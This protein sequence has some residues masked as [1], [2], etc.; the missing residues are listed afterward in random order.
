MGRTDQERVSQQQRYSVSISGTKQKLVIAG[1]GQIRKELEK[2]AKDLKANVTFL[3][4]VS[5]ETH[6]GPR[7]EARAKPGGT[8]SVPLAPLGEG[9]L[10]LR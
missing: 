3:G 5:D 9:V 4:R 7:R 6:G 8:A 2:L 10:C 1:D